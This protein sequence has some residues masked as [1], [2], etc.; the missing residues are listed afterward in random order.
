MAA[1]HQRRVGGENCE[2]AG[3]RLLE[4]LSEI[5]LC[6]SFAELLQ[7]VER[8]TAPVTRF[9]SLAR[10]DTTL[11]IGAK[12]TTP[13]VNVMPTVVYLHAGTMEGARNLGFDVD[14]E[15]LT[16]EEIAELHPELLRLKEAYHIENFL[17][18]SLHF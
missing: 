18:C 12:L 3:K 8:V 15:F 5:E 1:S 17:C 2:D 6:K 13:E 14:Q 10:Y 4:C 9:G 11:R 16:M 7:L